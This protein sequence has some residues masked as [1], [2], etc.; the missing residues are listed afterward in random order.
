[1]DDLGLPRSAKLTEHA[2]P[3]LRKQLKPATLKIPIQH[4]QHYKSITVFGHRATSTSLAPCGIDAAHPLQSFSLFCVLRLALFF[5]HFGSRPL[6][7][8]EYALAAP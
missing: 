1:M 8:L 5:R 6:V 4:Q 7:L 2:E 3:R